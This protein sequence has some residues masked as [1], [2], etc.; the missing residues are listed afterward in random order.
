MNCVEIKGNANEV[1][2]LLSFV[3]TE[4]NEFDFNIIVP[5]P[6]SVRNTERGSLSFASEAVSNYL[7]TNIVSTHLQFMMDRDNVTLENIDNAIKQWECDKKID[8]EL[9]YRIIDNKVNY[10]GCGDWYEWALEYWG[11]KWDACE[12]YINDNSIYFDT[13]WT[14]CTLVIQKLAELYPWLEIEHSYFEPGVP[15][16][17]VD[18]YKNGELVSANMYD[19]NTKEFNRLVQFF[20][21]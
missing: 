7:R 11:T 9:G 20:N 1:E 13:A 18:T 19:S 17:G 14:P 8:I 10:N 12:T 5:M 16:A 4:D 2:E 15:L 21:W 3:K 6:E